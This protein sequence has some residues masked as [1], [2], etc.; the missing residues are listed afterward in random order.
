MW[1]GSQTTA[2]LHTKLHYNLKTV[3]CIS[4]NLSGIRLLVSFHNLLVLPI[5]YMLA[6]NM[7]AAR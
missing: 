6:Q 4:Y 5:G 2:L 1:I 3:N 7:Y